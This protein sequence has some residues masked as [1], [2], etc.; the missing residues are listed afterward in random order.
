[1]LFVNSRQTNGYGGIAQLARALGS[2][3][4]CRWFK[5]YSRYHFNRYGPVVKRS[6]HRPFTA[7]TR[8]RFSSGSPKSTSHEVLFS[9][10]PPSAY[11][12]PLPGVHLTSAYLTSAYHLTSACWLIAYSLVSTFFFPDVFSFLGDFSC[13]DGFSFITISLTLTAF[14]PRRIISHRRVD[15]LHILLP[16]RFSSPMC[17]LSSVISHASTVSPS[18]RFLLL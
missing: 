14:S 15:A 4:G 16:Q 9:L 2:Y 10:L 18:R 13:I 7:V 17:F 11:S 6:R 1:M 3:P 12:L 5:S 8:V